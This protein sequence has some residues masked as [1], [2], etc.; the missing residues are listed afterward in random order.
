MG[1]ADLS[2]IFLAEIALGMVGIEPAG[3]G[4]RVLT[5]SRAETMS[6]DA[7]VWLCRDAGR[8]R[9]VAEIARPQLR[10]LAVPV[11]MK[12]A[13]DHFETIASALGVILVKP[14]SVRVHA[15]S[16]VANITAHFEAMRAA[17]ELKSVNKSYREYR[18]RETSAGNKPIGYPTFLS[19]YLANIV[20]QTAQHSRIS[21]LESVGAD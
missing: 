4:C 3:P 6:R 7:V 17:G 20:K 5:N 16:V 11:D 21:F 12:A 13:A 18:L 15:Q 9:L 2:S 10:Q 8:A 19:N 1:S 14:D